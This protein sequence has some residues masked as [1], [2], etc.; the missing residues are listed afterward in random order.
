MPQVQSGAAVSLTF[1]NSFIVCYQ[2]I[3]WHTRKWIFREWHIE[4]RSIHET[5]FIITKWVSFILG[6]SSPLKRQCFWPSKPFLKLKTTM[7]KYW[8]LIKIKSGM[9]C[10]CKES[11]GKMKIV[12]EQRLQLRMKFILA[13]NTKIVI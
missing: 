4:S 11:E 7:C 5:L 13:Y 9:T 6:W 2:H 3:V 8:T 10:V 1:R 12:Q